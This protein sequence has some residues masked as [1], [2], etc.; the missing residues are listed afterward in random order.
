ME[1]ISRI[2]DSDPDL[3]ERVGKIL[4][5]KGLG[6]LS[7][8]TII[9]ETNGFALFENVRQLTS[10]AGY[11]VVENQSGKRSGKTKIS[12]MGNSHIRRMMYMPALGVV[13]Y[14]EENFVKIYNRIYERTRV[15]MKAYVAIQ[16]KLLCMI[17]ILWKN[18]AEYDPKYLNRIELNTLPK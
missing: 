16:R 2:I 14:K 11:D 8:A 12:K 18:N 7:V 3:K 9:A 1:Q 15:K 5:I 10:Y 4:K 6:L 17:Y 13:K